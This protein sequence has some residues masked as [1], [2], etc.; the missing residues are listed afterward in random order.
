MNHLE[1]LK[2]VAMYYEVCHVIQVWTS[3]QKN[4]TVGCKYKSKMV[5]TR[6]S[7]EPV[8]DRVK[9]NPTTGI[10]IA[11]TVAIVTATTF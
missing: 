8:L 7:K 5:A 1:T 9:V 10:A 4:L 2:I 3:F 6:A 11:I